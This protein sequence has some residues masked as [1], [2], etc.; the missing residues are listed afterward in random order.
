M[1]SC[2][3]ALSSAPGKGGRGGGDILA[4]ALGGGA[5]AVGWPANPK[6]EY[7]RD[8]PGMVKEAKQ[9]PLELTNVKELQLGSMEQAEG[10]NYL[11]PSLSTRK[12][13]VQFLFT[14]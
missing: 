6:Q 8:P 7:M 10:K 3:P 2:R 12:I 14:Y 9:G 5:Q 11:S 13:C 1:L 4:F